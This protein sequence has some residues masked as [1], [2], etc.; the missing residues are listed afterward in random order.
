MKVRS[1]WLLGVMSP[2]WMTACG[3]DTGLRGLNPDVSDPGDDPTDPIDEDVSTKK[4]LC[5]GVDDNNDGQIDE[6]F[7][8][9]DMD[10]IKDCVDTSCDI[11]EP[12]EIA[13]L[14]DVCPPATPIDPW[15]T[16]EEWHWD[17]G[18]IA[19]SPVV[20]DLDGDGN[21]EV[22]FVDAPSIYQPGDLVALDGKTG[23][24]LVWEWLEKHNMSKFV[25]KI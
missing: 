25:S 16:A 4:E 23:T 6:G 11:D 2:I 3:L 5:N 10:G 22:I 17:K 18:L 9:T 13:D 1:I 24:E 12:E 21:A 15:H 8:D 20:G 14:L 7:R 19:A